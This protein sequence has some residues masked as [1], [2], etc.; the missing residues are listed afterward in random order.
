MYYISYFWMHFFSH[1]VYWLYTDI[2]TPQNTLP[3]ASAM[4]V[5]RGR[6]ALI[7][8]A[9]TLLVWHIVAISSSGPFYTFY[10]AEEKEMDQ[11]KNIFFGKKRIQ[12]L[13]PFDLLGSFSF[14][15]KKLRE[16]SYFSIVSEFLTSKFQIF[17]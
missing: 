17:L 12:L 7:K 15:G 6:R 1:Y 14:G 9:E 4:Y 8:K 13:T 2:P 3:P 5:D 11:G 10:E 16:N